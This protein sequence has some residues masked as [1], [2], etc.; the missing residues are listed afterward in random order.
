MIEK[1]NMWE[2]IKLL[3]RK[4]EFQNV[5]INEVEGKNDNRK[6]IQCNG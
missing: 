1:S 3:T 2:K 5:R 6:Q 4:T